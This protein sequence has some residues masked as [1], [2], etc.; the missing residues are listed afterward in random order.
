VS[1]AH[2]LGVELHITGFVADTEFRDNLMATDIGIQLRVSPLLGVSGP[3][4]DLAAFGTTSVASNGLA[5]DVDAP[6][7]VK[8]LPDWISPVMVAQEVEKLILSPLTPAEK[9]ADRVTYLAG[10]D[11]KLYAEKL[12]E[13]IKAVSFPR[14]L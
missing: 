9:E 2:E 14:E 3:L 6:S 5:V 11:T 8:R 7:Y 4:S 12:L 10:K 1:R 13:V